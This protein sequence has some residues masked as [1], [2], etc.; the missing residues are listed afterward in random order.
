MLQEVGRAV[1]TEAKRSE[2]EEVLEDLGVNAREVRE[3]VVVE[4]EVGRREEDASK[5]VMPWRS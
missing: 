5:D 2:G 1:V 4:A 3:L